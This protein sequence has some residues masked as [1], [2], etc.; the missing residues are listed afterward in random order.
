MPTPV[1]EETLTR[2]RAL[3]LKRILL[4][5]DL[6]DASS[7]AK[8]WTVALARHYGAEVFLGHAVPPEVRGFVPLDV[9]PKELDRDRLSAERAMKDLVYNLLEERVVAHSRL[10]RGPVWE[11]ISSIIAE[12]NIDLL[13]L[14][15]HGRSGL[16]K[17]AL[18]SVAEQLL[19]TVTCPVLTI[20]RNAP[21]IDTST[22]HFS[23][24]LFSTDFGPSTEK[25]LGYA[26][27]LAEE[28][29]SKL[30]VLHAIPR[31]PV[32][33]IGP[34]LY[35]PAY[36]TA[37]DVMKWE[38]DA[39]E[40]SAK[41]LRAMIPA[42]ANLAFEPEFE[43]QA[44]F[45]PRGI[46]NAADQHNVDLIVMGAHGRGS[47]RMAAHLPW[48]AVHGVISEARCPVLTIMSPA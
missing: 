35:C 14:G 37:K 6:S 28:Y 41:K 43:I 18:G 16:S 19:R 25:S 34:G 2:Q 9:L 10:Q 40:E 48:S 29:R 47:A 5:T 13:V 12:E 46:M 22:L 4:A 36:Y 30:I 8:Q 23:R 38:A 1:M 24:I 26:L 39:R 31:I 42:D 3:A 21:R 7:N 33:D 32:S 44:D 20:G 15:T 11:V 17:V 27:S 45:L